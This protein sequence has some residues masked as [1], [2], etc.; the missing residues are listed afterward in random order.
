V[1]L[2]GLGKL[3]TPKTSSGIDLTT[4]RLVAK[5][6]NQLRYHMPPK[7]TVS[8]NISFSVVDSF[9]QIMGTNCMYPLI[10]KRAWFD[11][12]WIKGEDITGHRR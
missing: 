6:L 12:V 7:L 3:K 8:R 1:Q 11:R 5:S 2:E 9:M 10:K 4:F